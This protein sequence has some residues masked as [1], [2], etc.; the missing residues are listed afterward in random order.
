MRHPGILRGLTRAAATGA[1]G[2]G[3]E[4]IGAAGGAEL[5][6]GPGPRRGDIERE[7]AK[8][9]AAGLLQMPVEYAA[10]KLAQLYGSRR[11]LEQSTGW[12][13][14]VFKKGMPGLWMEKTDT[15]KQILEDVVTG[16]GIGR[17]DTG[18]R[19]T[20]TTITDTVT[21]PYS[22][23][24]QMQQAGIK[25]GTT[26]GARP[27]TLALTNTVGDLWTQAEG[28]KDFAA[29]DQ[30]K[31][32]L[33]EGL[34]AVKP[35]VTAEARATIDQIRRLNGWRAWI[36]G[37]PASGQTVAEMRETGMKM[38]KDL[39]DE[40]GM[41]KGEGLGRLVQLV[42]HTSDADKAKL[43]LDFSALPF[44]QRGLGGQQV[45]PGV[46][47]QWRV[48]LGVIPTLH[49]PGTVP[50]VP[51]WESPVPAGVRIPANLIPSIVSTGATGVTLPRVWPT[52]WGQETR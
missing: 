2:G 38:M 24:A 29:R 37:Q 36:T 27:G 17:L 13:S 9:A 45:I 41:L 47:P 4:A 25:V 28:L 32:R 18:L 52:S 14:D 35:E 23:V 8:G 15:P 21:V 34:S 30:V 51:G 40:H 6:Y 50:Y 11:A 1:V 12:F 43:G 3:T 26:A 5:G 22:A 7:A 39:T 48:H 16:A 44:A 10:G 46:D 31:A 49:R 20:M 42:R 33:L 19:E